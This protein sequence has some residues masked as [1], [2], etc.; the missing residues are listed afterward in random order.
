MGRLKLRSVQ[1]VV[2]VFVLACVHGPAIAQQRIALV[3]GNGAYT[4]IPSLANPAN[5]AS[6]VAATLHAV[7][8]EVLSAI[9]VDQRQ[10]KTAI[11]EF[12]EKLEKAGK[13]AVGLFYYAGHGVQANGRNYLIPLGAPILRE[14]DLEVEAVAADWVLGGMEFA[15][16][17]LNILILDACR[18]NPFKRS[19][20]ASARGLAEMRAPTGAYISYATAPGDVASD[21]DPNEPN[22]PFTAALATM[23]REPGLKVEEVFKN[24][25]VRVMAET[26][27]FQVPWEASS[28]TGDFFFNPSPEASD[29]TVEDMTKAAADKETVF[30]QSIQDSGNPALFEA[31]LAQYPEGAYALIAQIKVEQLKKSGSANVTDTVDKVAIKNDPPAAAIDPDVV[32]V[33]EMYVPFEDVRA[34]FQL[35]VNQDSTYN[36]TS[37]NPIFGPHSG[38]FTT[39]GGTWSMRGPNWQDEGTYTVPDSKTLVM[40]G[41]YGTGAWKR[42]SY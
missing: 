13:D 29:E 5:D 3:V 11:A 6:L 39:I 35:V 1:F 18:N 42:V 31:Y 4:E 19:F 12:S 25:R 15:G 34:R 28:L 37:D 27:D 36:F 9:D 20:R 16:N 21:G 40:S 23:I 30:W 10:M 41:R 38:K 14:R 22:S 32:G 24:V 2:C 26:Q 8:F 33:W 7:G 17:A